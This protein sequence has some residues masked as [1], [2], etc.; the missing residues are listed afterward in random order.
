MYVS[1]RVQFHEDCLMNMFMVSLE[2]NAQ[3]WYESLP[4]GCLYSL[5]DFH[6]IFLRNIKK[7]YPSLSLVQNCCEHVESFIQHLERFYEDEEFMDE[8]ILEALHE[9]PFQHQEVM[10]ESNCQDVVLPYMF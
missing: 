7:S 10:L 8:E 5:K 9:K 2:G 6:L 3:L 1:L 4:P